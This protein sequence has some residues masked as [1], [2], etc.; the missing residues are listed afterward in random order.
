MT[1]RLILVACM[2]ALAAPLCAETKL[3]TLQIPENKPAKFRLE[4]P[5]EHPGTLI[6]RLEWSIARRIALR[7][8]APGGWDPPQKR[9]GSSP[10]FMEVEIAERQLGDGPWTL[11]IHADPA[12]EGGEALMTVE[13]PEPPGAESPPSPIEKSAATPPPPPDPWMV[14]RAA[15]AGSPEAWR[16]LYESIETYRTLLDIPDNDQPV[17]SC[18]W[19][20]DLMRYLAARRDELAGSGAIPAEVTRAVLLEIVAA[21]RSVEE[22]RLSRDPVVAGPRPDDPGRRRNWL[23]YRK[24][25]FQPLEQELDDLLETLRRNRAPALG[26]EPWPVRMVSCLTAC[27]RYFEERVRKGERQAT[28]REIALAQWDRLLAAAAALEALGAIK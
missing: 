6:L 24:E 22:M 8:E 28:N 5:I 18:R 13:L 1:R 20:D 7:L 16:R 4:L 27:E 19:Q 25:R 12:R 11:S 10:L 26:E 17:D 3:Y 9:D 15:P 2:M 21:I 14:S 23:A